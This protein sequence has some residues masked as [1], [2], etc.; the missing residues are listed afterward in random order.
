MEGSK[1]TGYQDFEWA[2]K[3]NRITLNVI[4]LWP[5]AQNFREKLLCDLRVLIVFLGITFGILIPALHSLMRISGDILLMLDNLQFTLPAISCTIRIVI[6]WW[7]KEAIVPIINMIAEDWINSKTEQDRNMMIKRAQI[8]RIIITCA[9]CLMGVAFFFIIILPG[10]G[11]SMRVTTNITDPGRPMLIQTYY[12]Y[13]ITKTPQYELTFIVQ[14]VYIMLAMMSYTGVDNFLGLLV[15]HICGQ[16]DILK[17]RLRHLDTYINSQDM[18]KSCIAKHIRLLRAISVIEDTYN[19]TLLALFI[20][21]A[22]LF[23]FYGFRIINLFDDGNDLSITHLVYFSSNVFNF[24][25]HMCLY[26]ALG[27]ILLGQCNEIYSAAY[28]NKWYSVDPKIAK[29]LLLLLIRG[30]KPVYLTAGKIFPMTMATFCG[31]I[32]TSAGYISVLH[33]TRN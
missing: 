6:F 30:T 32:K 2:V 5:K 1:C 15:F 3:L 19:I 12:I 16:L 4:G 22:I 17:N 24:F 18:L 14:A 23:S 13:D 28:D 31:L 9:Y 25:A 21:F 27:E 33:T 20:Y 10:F 8:P 7:K 29:D 26:C 11:L